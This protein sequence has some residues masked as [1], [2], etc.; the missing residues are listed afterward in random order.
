VVNVTVEGVTEDYVMG[1]N[2]NESPIT[3]RNTTNNTTTGT[4]FEWRGARK[5]LPTG[6]AMSSARGA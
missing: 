5:H 2:A 1:S 3:H 4:A 6:I